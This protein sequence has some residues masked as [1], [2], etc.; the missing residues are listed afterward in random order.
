MSW[1]FFFQSRKDQWPG[2]L[3]YQLITLQEIL[4]PRINGNILM[5]PG[6]VFLFLLLSIIQFK[7][8]LLN[9][10]AFLLVLASLGRYLYRNQR[11]VSYNQKSQF[12]SAYNQNI[13]VN[14][15]CEAVGALGAV[16]YCGTTQSLILWPLVTSVP[17]SG[18]C[19]PEPRQ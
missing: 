11:T 12:F 6:I 18:S 14:V 17:T 1:F 3:T 5:T 16:V 8:F 13:I 7:G 19:S 10:L 4:K 9:A 15:I 2:H